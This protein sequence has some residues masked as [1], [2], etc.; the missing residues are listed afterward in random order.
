[1]VDHTATCW[2]FTGVLLAAVRM[3]HGL[4][5]MLKQEGEAG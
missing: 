4:E 1:M 5:P 3:L 2:V